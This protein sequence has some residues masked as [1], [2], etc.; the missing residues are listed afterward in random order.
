MMHY[1]SWEPRQAKDGV[2][3]PQDSLIE[4][5][6]F[7]VKSHSLLFTSRVRKSW[8]MMLILSFDNC[9][10][11]RE[12]SSSQQWVKALYKYERSILWKLIQHRGF[13]QYQPSAHGVFSSWLA[14]IQETWLKKLQVAFNLCERE[15]V[16]DHEV[17]MALQLMRRIS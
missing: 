10:P 1:L 13:G 4:D 14:M 8:K 11:A 6:W 17:S 15:D 9:K 7:W 12:H 16:A 3:S 5:H 2:L